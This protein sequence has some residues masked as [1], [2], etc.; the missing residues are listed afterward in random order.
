MSRSGFWVVLSRG[1]ARL[2]W[3]WS[4]LVDVVLLSPPAAAALSLP[5]FVRKLGCARLPVA[6]L[7]VLSWGCHCVDLLI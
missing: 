7:A 1:R 4:S 3:T 5:S 2:S 6:V